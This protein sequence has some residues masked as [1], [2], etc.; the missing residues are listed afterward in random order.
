MVINFV[1]KNYAAVVKED[2]VKL[3]PAAD[4]QL[5]IEEY[6]GIATMPPNSAFNKMD[7]YVINDK[8][9]SIDMDL[10]Y[11]DKQ[12]DLTLSC[13]LIEKD[14]KIDYSIESIHIL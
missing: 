8:E 12:S 10:W 6:P 9:I 13:R 7:I 3:I 4:I 1:E 5:A 2:S 14:G 11:D